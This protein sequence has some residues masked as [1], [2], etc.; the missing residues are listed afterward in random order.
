[1]DKKLLIKS[2]YLHFRD[3]R[4]DQA[5]AEYQKLL[6][7]DPAD[8]NAL[9]MLGDIFSRN[10]KALEAL[11]YYKKAVKYL[12]KEEEGSSKIEI[13]LR[14]MGK[15]DPDSIQEV[16]SEMEKAGS[17]VQPASP[18]DQSS[19]DALKNAIQKD[20]KN[21]E[22]YQKLGD[23]LLGLGKKEDAAE[24]YVVIGNAL[25]NN[26]M[27]KK[28]EEIFQKVIS[29]DPNHVAA[30]IVLGEIAVKEGADSEAKKEFLLVA[31]QL[32]RQGNLEK[33][34]LFAQKSIQLK[35]I[36]AHYYLGLIYYQKNRLEE[37]RVEFETLLKF[38]VNHQ[39]A[40]T[41]LAQIQLRGGQKEEA[42]KF[43]ERLVKL[44]SKNGD[45]WEKLGEVALLMG[46][47]KAAKENFVQAM[48]KFAN[49]EAWEHAASC[50]NQAVKLDPRNAEL[51]QKLA[52]ASYNAGLEHQAA[53]ACQAL[54]EIYSAEGK[55][56][57]A[58]QMKAKAQELLGGAPAPVVSQTPVSAP[59]ESVP[60]PPPKPVSPEEE[61]R[62]MM[63]LAESYVQQGALDEAIEVYQKILKIQ[64]N[65]ENVRNALTRVYAMFAG[66]NP[67]AAVPRKPANPP[68]AD[69]KQEQKV[70]REARERAQREAQIRAQ[71]SGAPAP[72]PAKAPAPEEGLLQT[73]GDNRG[74]QVAGDQHDEFMTVT[75]AEIYTKQG[76][77][78]E[79]LK[80]YQK[81]LE[82]EPGNLEAQTKKQ[83]LEK[84][85]IEQEKLRRHSEEAAARQQ[86]EPAKPESG[87]ST[88][89][90]EAVDSE[91]AGTDPAPKNKD[92][93]QDPPEAGGRRGRVSYV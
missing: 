48:E 42:Y 59:P 46:N 53:E 10:G 69:E 83:E 17:A 67:E 52:D 31:E 24:Q 4:L 90:G 75:V 61:L 55:N 84:K 34:L 62:S 28:A 29:I 2:A 35:S 86:S 71:R 54:A 49:D 47:E 7:M 25:F 38:K 58:E 72:V 15:L 27:Y 68:S 64:P 60:A 78:N 44:D 66:L 36:E 73:L 1:M 65:Q 91:P 89:G 93:R 40:L 43:Y 11:Q 92:D 80:I 79:A 30:H 8:S 76:L 51:Y 57:E 23:L 14:K 39:G 45:A 18:E 74:D 56:A 5:V 77:L 85:M 87:P 22:N 21:F 81:I 41:H 32:I 37:A 63:N 20:P 33:G 70:Q 13:I 3:G 6:E 88:R 9:N 82:I 16:T 19:V 50:A 26:K 12:Q